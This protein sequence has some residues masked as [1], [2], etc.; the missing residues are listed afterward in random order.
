M[1]DFL[2]RKHPITDGLFQDP[3]TW[4]AFAKPRGYPGDAVLMDL[5]YHHPSTRWILDKTTS[6]G[7]LVFQYSSN[8]EAPR[9]VRARRDL[10]AAEIDRVAQD[11]RRPAR[12]LALACGHLREAPLS[13]AVQD[14]AL[15]RFLALDQDAASIA[16][17]QREQ[18]AAGVE[19]I[20][21]PVRALL[22]E[23]KRQALGA[24]DFV[25]AAGLFDYLSD[26]LATR[27]LSAM[28]SLLSPGGKLWACNFLPGIPAPGYMEAFMDW[29]LIYRDARQMEALLE[30]IPREQIS[31][32]RTF[33]ERHRNVV[34]LEVV[35]NP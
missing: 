13:A 30:E 12:V 27:L 15:G 32:H 16:V 14:G 18:A 17:V 1:I 2:I 24:F 9:A 28:F 7:W 31:A 33:T 29:W 21:A 6:L 19:A 35:R 26:R 23:Q 8:S 20:V 22:C 5:M 34:F 4:R 11:S 3:F 25:Y 10:L